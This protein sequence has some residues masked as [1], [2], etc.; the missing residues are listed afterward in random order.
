MKTKFLLLAILP[1]F[2]FFCTLPAQETH[3]GALSENGSLFFRAEPVNNFFTDKT[4]EIYYYVHLQGTE[5]DNTGIRKHVPLNISVVID[6]SGSM[7]GDKLFHTK[8]AVKF[9]VGQLDH[10]DVLSIVLYDTGVEV[11]LSPQHVEDK[12]AL[13]KRID[14]IQ[15]QGSTNLEG[16][17]RKGYELVQSAEK[18]LDGEMVN[19]VLLLSDGLANVGMSSPE[20]LSAITAGFFKE[21]HISISTFGVGQDYN[22]DLMAK[23]ALEGGGKYY[24]ISSPETLSAVFGEELNV[25]SQVVAKNTKLKI[26]FPD[27]V[28]TYSRT[29]AYNSSLTGNTLEL[30][31]NDIF[32]NEQKSVLICFKTNGKLK[33]PLSIEC[34]LSY[35]N[36]AKDSVVII[37]DNRKSELKKAANDK[38]YDGGYNHAAS[39]GY[40]LEISA[41]LYEQANQLCDIGHFDEAKTKVK[42]AIAILDNHFAN[43]GENVFLRDFEKQLTDYSALIEDMK[44]M[45]ARTIHFNNTKYKHS[46]FRTVACPSF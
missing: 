18:L 20:Q 29:Y 10:S 17:I 13:L 19:R 1:A 30:D 5:K 16:G 35:S 9:L 27:D 38:E 24:F 41:D 32:A 43:V 7:Y 46:H 34:E 15:A 6:R 45:D 11:F 40:A 39:E 36:A 8:E 23:V 25:I 12:A 14:A 33:A 37:T 22:E 21:N 44:H 42:E 26:K 2:F 28:L 3:H 31:F 4:N